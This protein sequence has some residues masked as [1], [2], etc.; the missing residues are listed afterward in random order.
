MVIRGNRVPIEEPV[1]PE[2]KPRRSIAAA[3]IL[4]AVIVRWWD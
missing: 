2:P 1:P 3:L 4:I